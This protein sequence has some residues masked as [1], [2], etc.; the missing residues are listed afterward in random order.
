MKVL[1]GCG[2][3]TL[4]G[5]STCTVGGLLLQNMI[6]KNPEAF[7][8]RMENWAKGMV[9]KDWNR[10]RLLVEQLQTDEA[11]IA[12]YR[13]NSDLQRAYLSEEQ[14]LKAVQGWRSRLSPLPI[15]IPVEGPRR[16]H[17]P[18]GGEAP[19]KKNLPSVSFN[20]IFGTTNIVCKYPDGTR[21]TVAFKEDRIISIAVD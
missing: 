17:P 20:K 19:D 12:V 8:R 9:Q 3:V 18:R 11:T 15:E 6:K 2:V 21:L 16:R 5:I 4:L 7:E 1:L 14:F 10:L 13:S